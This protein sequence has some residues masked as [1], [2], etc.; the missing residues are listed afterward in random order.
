M[1]FKLQR[2]VEAAEA[3]EAAV[4]ACPDHEQA[5]ANPG[6]CYLLLDRV[7]EAAQAFDPCLAVDA[8]SELALYYG[9]MAYAKL[10]Q[11]AQ[12]RAY[13]ERVLR[14]RPDW[15]RVAEVDELLKGYVPAKPRWQFWK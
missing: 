6:Q 4:R 2:H 5:W 9:A 12:V 15:R 8:R 11:P 10:G 13:L 14:N 3:Y 7:P 1:L